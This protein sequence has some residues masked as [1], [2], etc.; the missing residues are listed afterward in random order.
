LR[1]A[2]AQPLPRPAVEFVFDVLDEGVVE[3]GQVTALGKVL[4][5]KAV[6]VLVGA[7]LP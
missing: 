4:A 3:D 2:I 6:A 7:A 5:K 1:C